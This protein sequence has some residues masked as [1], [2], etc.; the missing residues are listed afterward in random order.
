MFW[1]KIYGLIFNTIQKMK[2]LI[3]IFSLSILVFA[4]ANAQN[5]QKDNDFDDIG[6]QMQQMQKMMT[7]QMKKLFGTDGTSRD[8]REGGSDSTQSFN[9]SFKNLPFGQ[10]DTAMTQSFSMFFDGK[11]WQNL[12]DT[13]MN[14]SMKGLRDRM[15]DFGKGMNIDDLFKSFG[16]LM[17]NGS[18]FSPNPDDM[19]RVS[20]NKKKQKAEEPKQKGKYKTESL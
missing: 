2:R 18:P 20:P 12:S 13:S 14:E 5:S 1:K 4:S 6:K 7:E 19:P 3:S 15:P 17:Q 10:M 16:D 11:N 8:N 9:F